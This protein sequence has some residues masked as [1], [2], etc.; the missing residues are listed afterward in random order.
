MS[1]TISKIKKLIGKIPLFGICL[2]HQLI[3]LALGAKT[4]KLKFGHR[5]INHPVKDLQTGRVFITTQNHGFAVTNENL[6]KID[7][8]KIRQILI[9]EK[10][11]VFLSKKLA[12]IVKNV[13]LEIDINKM[14][15]KEFNKKLRDFFEK[16]QIYSLK[17]RFFSEKKPLEKKAGRNYGPPGSKKIVYFIDDYIHSCIKIHTHKRYVCLLRKNKYT[18]QVYSFAFLNLLKIFVTQ[19]VLR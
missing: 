6:E 14:E 10:N 7:S 11:N 1:E 15:F 16:Y 18:E 8:K 3:A 4:F 13:P 19:L 12:T 5:G 17:K 9:K 2:G